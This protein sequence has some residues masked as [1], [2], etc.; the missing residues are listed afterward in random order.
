MSMCRI[1]THAALVAVPVL[2]L[3]CDGNNAEES[4]REVSGVEEG[5]ESQT[6]D[7]EE[8]AYIVEEIDRIKDAETGE[9][10]GEKKSQT[11]VVV[12]EETTV[13]KDVDVK[14]GRTAEQTTGYVPEELEDN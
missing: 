6:V 10:V 8:K 9:V 12:Q 14:S 5:T 11:E 13:E 7:V 3:G 1:F 2:L 4:V